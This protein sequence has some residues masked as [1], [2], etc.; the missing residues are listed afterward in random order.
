MSCVV[1]R[2]NKELDIN[3]IELFTNYYNGIRERFGK[4][5][6]DMASILQQD[7][8]SLIESEVKIQ[9]PSFANQP[10]ELGMNPGGGSRATLKNKRK[11]R[12]KN[13][14]TPLKASKKS[15]KKSSKNKRRSSKNRRKR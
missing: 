3:R 6:S 13:K 7:A 8:L 9:T 14:K 15:N 1:E 2:L 10:S 4:I 5:N 12:S 11:R